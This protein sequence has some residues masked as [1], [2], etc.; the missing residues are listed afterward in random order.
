VLPFPETGARTRTTATSSTTLR[1]TLAMMAALPR[2]LDG[3]KCNP[4]AVTV[5]TE[6]IVVAVVDLCTH[7]VVDVVIAVAAVNLF[8]L[9]V[10]AIIRWTA[11]R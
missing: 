10:A 11:H 8:S 3:I 9:A 4:S 6:F 5:V 2:G 7:N 1:T